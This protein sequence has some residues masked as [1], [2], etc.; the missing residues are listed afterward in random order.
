MFSSIKQILIVKLLNQQLLILSQR[1]KFF[2]YN[3][4]FYLIK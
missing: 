2:R 3:R 4:R 1:Y